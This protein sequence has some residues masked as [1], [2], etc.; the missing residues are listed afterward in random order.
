MNLEEAIDGD[1]QEYL[2]IEKKGMPV[3]PENILK[4]EAIID[5]ED[6]DRPD[7]N[8]NNEF[9]LPRG[10][11]VERNDSPDENSKESDN[12][13]EGKSDPEIVVAQGK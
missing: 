3:L 11:V 13:F 4:S 8:G 6:T 12:D 7:L 5:S 2:D 9:N 10:V 1:I